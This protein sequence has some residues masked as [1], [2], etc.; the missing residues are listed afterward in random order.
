MLIHHNA[1]VFERLVAAAVELARQKALARTVE[2]RRVNNYHVVLVLDVSDEPK[3][4]F[5]I[6]GHALV[7]KARCRFGEE[8][9]A[10]FNHAVVN[11]HK[12]NAFKALVFEQFLDNATVARTK[13][14]HA[15]R[16]GMDGHWHVAQHFVV[17]EL[18]AVSEDDVA[19]N[20]Q[21]APKLKRLENI[22]APQIGLVAVK[23]LVHFHRELY[24]FGMM[25]RKPEFHFSITD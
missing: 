2:S 23:V 21:K 6:D 12:V 18:V 10:G 22:D 8:F 17:D 9:A 25:F 15:F 3:S 13:N 1:V 19:V 7:V 14:Q 20:R 24:V 11:F 4:V 5:R 16:V